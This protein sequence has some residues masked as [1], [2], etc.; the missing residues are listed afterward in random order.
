MRVNTEHPT[1]VVAAV[2]DAQGQAVGMGFSQT[3]AIETQQVPEAHKQNQRLDTDL[4]EH[5][6]A[7]RRLEVALAFVLTP[8]PED[9][10][11]PNS[12]APMAPGWSRLTECFASHSSRVEGA[13]Q[14]VRSI[15]A[16]L[17]I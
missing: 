13:T 6:E 9:A 4:D 7:I 11:N 2:R 5:I 16:R 3:A 12:A 10:V 17:E 15:I 14:V 1:D 8:L